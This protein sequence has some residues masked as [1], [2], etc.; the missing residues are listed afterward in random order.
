M[1]KTG[2]IINSEFKIKNIV[3]EDVNSTMSIIRPHITDVDSPIVIQKN[4]GLSFVVLS[5]KI[6]NEYII[7]AYT[8]INVLNI[9]I[10]L[11]YSNQVSTILIKKK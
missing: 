1:K 4:A 6:L 5:L 8:A 2:V 10:F 3:F 9:P 11:L 7:N